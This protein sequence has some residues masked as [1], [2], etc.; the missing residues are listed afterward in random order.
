MFHIVPFF[1]DN[2][3]IVKL[4][5]LTFEEESAKYL[6]LNG[7]DYKA[8]NGT[9]GQKGGMFFW[10]THKGITFWLKRFVSCEKAAEKNE[11]FNAKKLPEKSY[12]LEFHIPKKDIYYPEW[13]LDFALCSKKLISLISKHYYK[14]YK[15]RLLN[16][17]EVS[18]YLN[19]PLVHDKKYSKKIIGLS[20]SNNNIEIKLEQ[21]QISFGTLRN[22]PAN[23]SGII[24]R[25]HDFLY[26]KSRA[27]ALEYNL[28]LKKMLST[29]SL[30]SIK[31]C[32]TK[33]LKP[34]AIEV[35]DTRSYTFTARIENVS[36]FSKTF[37]PSAPLQKHGRAERD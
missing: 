15:K 7:S 6:A 32:G 31:Y 4:Y 10:N 13:Q 12:I 29:K 28:F 26:L 20:L 8:T 27:Y 34:A 25:L 17:K 14:L 24:Q 1:K 11:F 21:G 30:M 33:T 5:H 37:D 35:W 36:V 9:G 16:G 23:Y 18:L 2:E 3:H 22:Y 19:C